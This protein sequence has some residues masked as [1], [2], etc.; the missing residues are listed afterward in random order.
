MA[1]SK[2]LIVTPTELPRIRISLC[3]QLVRAMANACFDLFPGG[4]RRNA[5]A[6]RFLMAA[7]LTLANRFDSSIDER[8]LHIDLVRLNWAGIRPPNGLSGN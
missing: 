1:K 4:S 3:S 8:S 5:L 7:I 2:P 6:R